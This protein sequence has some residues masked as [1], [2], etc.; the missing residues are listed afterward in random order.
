MPKNQVAS[1]HNPF[2]DFKVLSSD[3][4]V[5]ILLTGK[6]G[7]RNVER[8]NKQSDP[9]LDRTRFRTPEANKKMG[10]PVSKLF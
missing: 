2:P 9:T 8:K 7:V 5:S 4:D 1:T 3:L 10:H 6:E